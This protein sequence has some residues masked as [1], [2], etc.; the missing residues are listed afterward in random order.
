MTIYS[1]TLQKGLQ[2]RNNNKKRR[3][4]WLRRAL[5]CQVETLH[6][7]FAIISY[8]PWPSIFSCVR[9]ERFSFFLLGVTENSIAQVTILF[10]TGFRLYPLHLPQHLDRGNSGTDF[11]H[12]LHFSLSIFIILLILSGTGLPSKSASAD[13]SFEN[14]FDKTFRPLELFSPFTIEFIRELTYTSRSAKLWI[15]PVKLDGG[16]RRFGVSLVYP[17]S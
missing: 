4:T 5:K 11:R 13:F 3:K 1:R 15:F 17:S 9:R 12:V 7:D 2:G 16:K 14:S 8:V 6:N 10:V